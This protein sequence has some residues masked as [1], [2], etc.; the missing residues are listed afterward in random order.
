MKYSFK[1]REE[2][3]IIAKPV[4]IFSIESHIHKKST[5]LVEVEK[6]NQLVWQHEKW[7]A[8]PKMLPFYQRL[9]CGMT[10]R[11]VNISRIECLFCSSNLF[12]KLL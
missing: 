4:T 10:S 9:V 3:K 1:A 11:I 8:I 6:K 2:K 12:G 7:H 5:V